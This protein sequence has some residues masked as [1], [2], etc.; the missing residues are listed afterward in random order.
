MTSALPDRFRSLPF[1]HRALHDSHAGRPENSRSA[2]AAAVR[3]GYGIEIDLQ[4]SADGRAMVFHDYDLRRLTEESGPI[5]QRS[6]DDLSRIALRHGEGE[7]I[8][9]FS[10]VLDLVAGRMPLLV[11]IKDQD[12]AMGP[13]VGR[14]E[15]ATAADLSGYGGLVAVMSFNPNSVAEMARHAPGIPRGL[16]TSAYDPDDWN[17]NKKTCDRLRDIPDFDAVGACFIS[18]EAD[19]LDRHRVKQ[20]RGQ[21]VPVLCWTIRSPEAEARARRFADNVTFEGYLAEFPA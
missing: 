21:G 14:L 2:I 9:T 4:I 11:E 16:V 12:G 15:A 19:D 18:H 13:D 8:P 17:L 7:G 5:A 20:L 3:A 1:A 10:E 6:A